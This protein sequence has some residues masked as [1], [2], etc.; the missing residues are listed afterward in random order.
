MEDLIKILPGLVKALPGSEEVREAVLFAMWKKAAGE[1]LRIHAIPISV[2]GRKM[3]IAVRDP[4]WKKHL[5][6]LAAQLLERTNRLMRSAELKFLAFEVDESR[7]R[8]HQGAKDELGGSDKDPDT[9]VTGSLA[10]QSRAIR[11]PK[12]R[13]L[14]LESAAAYLEMQRLREKTSGDN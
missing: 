11:D 6:K 8:S 12:L 3:R 10:K 7:F 5:E 1:G 2:E 9:I 4:I 13:K 14:F